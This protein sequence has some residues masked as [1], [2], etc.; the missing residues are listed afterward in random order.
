V[1]AIAAVGTGGTLTTVVCPLPMMVGKPWRWCPPPLVEVLEPVV[2]TVKP[3]PLLVRFEVV[4]NSCPNLVIMLMEAFGKAEMDPLYDPTEAEAPENATEPKLARGN[5]P[6]FEDGA[7]SIHS[8][9]ERCALV[10]FWEIGPEVTPEVTSVMVNKKGLLEVVS[11][12][13]PV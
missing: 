10:S 7:S 11:P 13:G 8:A 3:S 9:E 4:S 12:A 1:V 5:P 2:V 6:L